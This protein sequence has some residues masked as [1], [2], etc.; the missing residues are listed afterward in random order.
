MTLDKAILE[1]PPVDVDGDGDDEVGV[2]HLAG[3]LEI[4]LGTKTNELLGGRGGRA[5]AVTEHTAAPGHSKYKQPALDAGSGRHTV[6]LD[7]HGWEGA[8][9]AAGNPLQWGDSPDPGVLT[10]AS[11]TGAGPVVQMM[12]FDRYLQVAAPDS[13]NPATLKVGGYAPGELFDTADL[14]LDHLDVVIESPRHNVAAE[15]PGTYSGTM[16]CVE[17][18]DAAAPVDATERSEF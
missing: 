16:T 13:R 7:F 10:P 9:D 6:Q 5:N 15:E 11:A 14:G 1:F 3:N 4:T 17:V 18:L 2:F 12:V 8:Q